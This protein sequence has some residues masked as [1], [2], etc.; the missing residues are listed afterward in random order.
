MYIPKPYFPNIPQLGNLELD[1]IFIE[2]GYPILFT[3]KNGKSLYLCIC[4]T[5]C[6]EQK[7]I[8]SETNI[9]V[10]R[11]MV[12]REIPISTAFKMIE[13]KSVI[14]TWSKSNPKEAYKIFPTTNLTVSEL[15]RVSLYLNEDYAD[16]GMEYIDSLVAEAHMQAMLEIETQIVHDNHSAEVVYSAYKTAQIGSVSVAYQSVF[17]QDGA[18]ED[19]INIIMDTLCTGNTIRSNSN[20]ISCSTSVCDNT[21]MEYRKIALAA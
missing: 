21:S 19:R 14:A 12:K 4:R 16:D 10:L 5:L 9:E 13:G 17:S 18:L 11:K 2:D 6:P 15:P 1:Y 3:C 20:P 8:I 7:W